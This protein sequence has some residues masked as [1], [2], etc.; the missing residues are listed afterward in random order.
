[1]RLVSDQ[2]LT[3][4]R[5]RPDLVP[6]ADSPSQIVLVPFR[7]HPVGVGRGRWGRTDLVPQV[8]PAE[9]GRDE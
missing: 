8:V 2:S 7:P 6:E 5:P 4:S 3:S 1:M 9:E